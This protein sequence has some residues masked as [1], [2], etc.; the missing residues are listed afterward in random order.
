MFA[1]YCLGYRFII[2]TTAIYT[3]EEFLSTLV[4]T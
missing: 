3:A 4:T 2:M 1:V